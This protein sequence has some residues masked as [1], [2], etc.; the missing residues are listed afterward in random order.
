MS[1]AW[2]DAR[3][4][5]GLDLGLHGGELVELAADQRDRGAERRQLVRGAAADAGAAA[6]DDDDLAGEQAGREDGSVVHVAFLVQ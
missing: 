4:A 1:Q 6:G 2:I 5:A 3:A